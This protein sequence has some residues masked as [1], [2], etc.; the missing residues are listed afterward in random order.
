MYCHL[1][2]N[3][4]ITQAQAYLFFPSGKGSRS[5]QE[6]RY[7]PLPILS[8]Q[9]RIPGPG[10]REASHRFWDAW[11]IVAPSPGFVQSVARSKCSVHELLSLLHFV[12]SGQRAGRLLGPKW[13][14]KGFSRGL[15]ANTA[16]LFTATP[17]A[18]CP[19]RDCSE[20]SWPSG[21]AWTCFPQTISIWYVR[22]S[23]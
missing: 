19:L 11:L 3:S 13:L 17:G 18:V 6:V 16:H 22:V 9:S 10:L 20:S 23:L 2:L 4:V 14:S 15:S 8:T 1:L 7:Y 21:C 5:P 12:Q